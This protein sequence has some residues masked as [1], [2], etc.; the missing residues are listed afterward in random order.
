MDLFELKV[1]KSS[2]I[3]L[4][5]LPFVSFETTVATESQ[6]FVK[7]AMD[8]I[9]SGMGIVILGPFMLVIAMLI[10]FTSSGPVLF[11]QQRVGLNG[12]IFRL[13][14][15]RTMCEG[16]DSAKAKLEGMNEMDG[17][18][19]K[20][21]KDP[22]ITPL[23]KILR[24]FSIDEL[25]QLY[26]VFAGHM[27]LIGP[28]ALPTYEV[29]RFDLWQR[30]RLSMRPG[31]TCLWQVMGRN[32]IGFD[33]WMKLDLYYLDNWSLWLDMKILVRTIPTVLFGMGAY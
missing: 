22:R 25:P 20:I 32:K 7:K 15:F 33:E 6:L 24:K 1:A 8:F 10:K 19:F 13:Y 9:L 29:A 26:N 2:H 12:R 27:S 3:D 4:D 11:K 17:P 23:G 28:R 14:K 21:R 5:G 31:I 30:R 16:A 18:V